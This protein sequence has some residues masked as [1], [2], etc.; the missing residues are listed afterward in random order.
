MKQIKS[1]CLN[2]MLFNWHFRDFMIKKSKNF[3]HF[4]RFLHLSV[5]YLHLFCISVNVNPGTNICMYRLARHNEL[6]I[7]LEKTANMRFF[8]LIFQTLNDWAII[9]NFSKKNYAK[10]L[11]FYNIRILTQ[12]VPLKFLYPFSLKTLKGSLQKLS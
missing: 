12:E 7:S 1:K 3:G 9:W 10:L 8:T 4:A 11:F 5:A 2:L 6:K